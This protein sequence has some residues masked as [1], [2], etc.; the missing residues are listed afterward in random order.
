MM[1]PKADGRRWHTAKCMARDH[2]HD[3]QER[4]TWIFSR[5]HLFLRPR[6]CR[7]QS[8]PSL[9]GLLL[10]RLPCCT[11]H[12]SSSWHRLWLPC[13]VKEILQP[14]VS[15]LRDNTGYII[16]VVLSAIVLGIALFLSIRGLTSQDAAKGF[17][18]GALLLTI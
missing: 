11:L 2:M 7:S 17:V 15:K 3:G 14:T 10:L 16:T 4:E 8:S 9:I 18:M 6:K 5:K 12:L 1:L 13:T